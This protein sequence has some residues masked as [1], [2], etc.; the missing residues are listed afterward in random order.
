MKTPA[1]LHFALN[2]IGVKEIAGA[3]ANARINLYH[4]ITTL[5]ATS[6]EVPWCASYTCWCLEKAGVKSPRSAAAR[7]FLNWGEVVVSPFI[8]CVVV[9]ARASANPKS[10]HVG[11][12]FGENEEHVF[13][14]SGNQGNQVSVAAF[15]K[16]QI[17][18]YRMPNSR[19]VKP[20]GLH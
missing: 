1:W 11:F 15:N 6:D 17:L 16:N 14:L 5:R 12:W 9:I 8:G 7:D 13:I 4:A 19:G 10:A 3:L 20:D 2:E 18:G